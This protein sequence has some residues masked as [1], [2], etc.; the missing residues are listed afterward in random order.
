MT[1]AINKFKSLGTTVIVSSQ[2]PRNPFRDTNPTPIYVGY[3]Q[4]VAASTGVTYVDHFSILK[5]EYLALGAN[6]VNPMFPNDN[7][8]N[9]SYLQCIAFHSHTPSLLKLHTS[10]TGSNYAA[11]AFLRG[12]LCGNNISLAQYISNK[13]VQPSKYLANILQIGR[14]SC[15]Y[16]ASC[17]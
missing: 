14:S 17:S 6:A 3:A 10:P 1:D 12:V 13:N 16:L 4:S 11:Q 7:V 2:T 8:S 9:S 15:E 5:R